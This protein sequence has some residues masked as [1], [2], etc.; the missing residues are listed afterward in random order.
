MAICKFLAVMRNRRAIEW[1]DIK[2]LTPLQ[3]MPYVADLFREV[4]GKDLQGLSGFTGW[5]GIGGYYHWKVAQLG[6]LHA[7]PRL[8]GQP[9][10]KGP[11]ARPSGRPHP[12]RLT[13]TGTPAT[14]RCQYG[15][16][17]T[18]DQGG[19]RFTSSQGGKTSTSSQGRKTS[20]SSQGR[21]TSTPCQ[22]SKPA[23]TGRGEKPTASGGLVDPSPER[24]RAGEGAWADWYQRTL[25]GAKGGTSEPQGPPYPIGTVQARR[26]AIGQIYNSVDDKDPPPPNIASEALRAY[27]SGVDPRTLKTWACQILCM[28]S[29]YHMACMTRGS[30]VTSPIL[31]RV[32]EDRL[33]PLTDYASPEDRLGMTDVR[34]RDHQART[35]CIAVWLHRLDMALG[36]EP[37]ASGSL[38]RARHSLGSLLAYFLGPG[39]TWSLQFEDVIDQVLRENKRHNERKCSESTSSLQKCRNR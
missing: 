30:P 20:T 11:V 8:Q 31:P 23:S 6:L 22:S 32:I 5:I 13:Q 28:T 19:K 7:C 34:V 27:Y 4:M 39:T 9:V 21:K 10:P 38:V 18:S 12:P 17:L 33:P 24:E 1:T 14:G 26:E 37:A 36:E 3:F 2:E 25:R 35:L 16:Q 15:A 29:E